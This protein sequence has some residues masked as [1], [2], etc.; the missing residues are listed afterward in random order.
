MERALAKAQVVLLLVILLIAAVGTYYIVQIELPKSSHPS[1]IGSLPSGP[2][3]TP[4]SGT[5]PAPTPT[6]T[7][8]PYSMGPLIA[9]SG[10]LVQPY[11]PGGP[12]IEIILQNNAT[13][14][15]ISLQADLSL[16]GR[17]YTYVFNDVSS[18]NPLL[19][20]QDAS[21]TNTLID[22]GIDTNQIY[23]MEI[24]GTL[25][26]GSTFD[27]ITPVTITLPEA[28]G[29]KGNLEL[30]MTLDKTTYSLGEPVN[31]TLAITNISDQTINFT[32]TGLNFDFQVYN[33]TN[34]VVYQYSNFI[35]IPQFI[36]ILPLPAGQSIS[37]NFTWLQTCNFSLQVNGDP[38]A[39]GT[40][41]IIGETGP[42]YGIQT[43]LI[44][45]TIE[46]P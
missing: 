13:I 25:Q 24:T 4:T 7:S 1:T 38:V 28:S 30:T 26:N 5:S 44:Q 29:A 36:A 37:A 31:L 8:A 27:Y 34:N 45:L 46:N 41:N 33:D 19:P 35:A 20:N 6:A 14:P 39:P 21:Q 12:T 2:T 40:Y 42:T 16:S 9:V 17:N 11:T 18:S 22:A 32:D 23:P 10:Y 15:V 43:T 3:P